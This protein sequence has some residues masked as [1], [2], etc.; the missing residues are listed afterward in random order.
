MRHIE[1]DARRENLRSVRL[2]ASAAHE[3]LLRFYRRQGYEERA[4]FQAYGMQ[5]IC[6]EKTFIPAS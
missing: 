3:L 4:R 5:P 1:V 2:D 6:F